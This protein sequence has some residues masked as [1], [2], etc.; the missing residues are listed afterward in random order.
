MKTTILTSAFYFVT[1]FGGFFDTG[2]EVFAQATEKPN[3]L[4]ITCE[5]MSLDLA[6]YGDSTIATPN[7]NRL[8]REGVRYKHA[9]S[10]AGVCA[11]SR[12]ALITGMYPT[13]IGTHNMRTLQA[14]SHEVPYYSAVL[15]PEVKTY[16]EYLRAGG[17]YCTN[18]V[19]TDFQFETPISAWDECSTSAHWRN[20]PKDKP[21]FAIFNF[22]ITHE[23]QIWVRKNEPLLVDP[24]K[25]KVPPIYP[26]TK[27]VRQ[28]IARNYSNII[29][30][31]KMVGKVLQELEEDGLMDNTIIFFYS[32]HGSGLPFY[33]RELY[34]RGL[35]V[36]LI[37]RYPGKALA[38]TWND[39]LVSFVDF[40]PSV[41]SLAGVPVPTHM[42]GQPFLGDQKAK[43][44]RQYIYAA[45]DRMDSEYDIVRAVK[46]KRYKYIR[47][48]QPQKPVMQN[49]QYRLNMDMMNE[50]IKLEKEGKLNETQSIWFR[51]TKPVEELYD[52]EVDPFEIHNLA[53]DKKYHD[54]L[55]ELRN[56]HEQWER[57]T[58]DLGFTP[59]KEVFLSMWPKGIQPVTQNVT[60]DF[61]RKASTVTL[62][63]QPDASIVYKTDP[64]DKVWL[65][66]TGP[67]KAK[68]KS[69]VR[70]TAIRYGYKQSAETILITP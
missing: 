54:K 69:E 25:V 15:P 5:D 70:A 32:D 63:C 41:L 61:D 68:P 62:T 26:D 53:E 8:A 14:I 31:D 55:V 33:K 45:R 49:I 28:D 17:Y 37:I 56:A 40:G 18:N 22:I 48:Y 16:S 20:R 58:R 59:E 46:D 36:P 11:P 12:S 1:I 10:I 66:Y 42:Q 43:T 35:R 19:K 64:A 13:T 2:F 29:E 23:S 52:T 47:N 4:W 6:S 7:I 57:D 60:A 51:K 27:T 30:M 21:F 24:A 67:F 9:Y 3:I 38:G 65:L 44:P 39:E 50:L 34:D